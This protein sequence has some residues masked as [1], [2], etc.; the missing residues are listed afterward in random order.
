MKG[1]G[2]DRSIWLMRQ[3][4]FPSPMTYSRSVLCFITL[5]DVYGRR[6]V[7]ASGVESRDTCSRARNCTHTHGTESSGKKKKEKGTLS[8]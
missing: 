4:V 2:Y 3:A 1:K 6:T 7:T 5:Q 8:N